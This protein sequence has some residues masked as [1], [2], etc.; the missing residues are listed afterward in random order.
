VDEYLDV[1]VEVNLP[2]RPADATLHIEI[3]GGGMSG[4]DNMSLPV[5]ASAQAF[6]PF[7]VPDGSVV[8]VRLVNKR[9]GQEQAYQPDLLDVLVGNECETPDGIVKVRVAAPV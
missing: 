5:V 7:E 3:A 9:G 1:C 6:G 8:K 4:D 2:Q